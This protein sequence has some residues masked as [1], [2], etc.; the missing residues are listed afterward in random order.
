MSVLLLS[1]VGDDFTG[2][3]DAMES[4]ARSGVK[5]VLFT[6]PPT[7]EQ[8]MGYPDL[9]AFGIASTTR[10]MP[11]D[12]VEKTLLPTFQRLHEIGAPIVH[13]KVCSTFDSSP[14]I[15]SI[16]RAIDLGATVFQSSV[17]PVVVAAPALGR[18]C[19][20]GNLFARSGK[21]SEPFRLDRHPS[22]SRHP[23][24]PMDEADL[25]LHLG[26][27][28]SKRIG[29]IDVVALESGG[30]HLD[31]E[32]VLIDLLFERQLATVGKLIDS[33]AK[34]TFVVGSSGVESALC[35]HWS[36]SGRIEKA[37]RLQPPLPATPIIA[38]CGSCSPVTAAQ[39]KRAI[40]DGFI[41]VPLTSEALAPAIDAIKNGDSVVV[42]SQHVD[43]GL[44]SNIGA[45]LGS[46]L[47]D[48]L[49]ETNVRRVL[50]AGGDTSGQIAKVLGIESME[51][52]AELT[53]GS[54]LVRVHSPYS[55]VDGIEM[56]F[57]GGQIGK[58]DFFR[59]V[60]QGISDG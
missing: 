24:T 27:Q 29:L 34:P 22:M 40:D 33:A 32:V 30:A 54:P 56:T 3:T 42:H 41:E 23:T 45:T 10:S 12:E 6:S 58:I 35:A 1:F 50:V 37:P 19:V 4:L 60:Q 53:R 15:G 7:P 43:P 8:M 17:V 38:V 57:K 28:T 26:K 59:Q 52:I 31:G 13:Y 16:G 46:V 51:M 18:W 2:S 21:E 25:R 14:T 55:S 39:I 49:C 9:Q 47:H 20:F 11:T 36:E 48:L 5:T 44:V